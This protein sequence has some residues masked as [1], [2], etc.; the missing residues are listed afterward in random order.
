MS[1]RAITTRG[2]R[3]KRGG[4]P[5]VVVRAATGAGRRAVPVAVLVVAVASTAAVVATPATALQGSGIFASSPHWVREFP[6]TA[7]GESSPLLVDL[8]GDGTEDVVVGMHNGT[9][10]ALNGRDGATLWER[11]ALTSTSGINSSPSAADVD[12]DGRPEV[13]IG[14]GYAEPNSG[15]GALLSF[16]HDGTPRAG[17]PFVA[18]DG[19]APSRFPGIHSSPAIGDIDRDGT[20]DV[21]FGSLGIK[22]IWAVD[23]NGNVK[24]GFPYYTDD[25]NFSTAALADLDGDGITDFV[26]G[27]DQTPGDRCGTIRGMTGSG[28]QLYERWMSEIVRSSPAV[29]DVDGDGT[30]EIVVGTG[31]HWS[32]PALQTANSRARCVTGDATKLF[33]LSA[34]GSGR[35]ERIIEMEGNTSPSPALADVNGDGRTDIVAV[36]SNQHV[37]TGQGGELRVID[38]AT[39]GT[40]LRTIPGNTR[41]DII[42]GPAVADFDGDGRQD[43]A[44]TTGSGTYV[45][46]GRTGALIGQ[47][48]VGRIS[49]GATPAI[50]DLDRNGS[51]E[52]ITAGFKPGSPP[53]A[54]VQRWTTTTR[55]AVSASS[56]PTFHHDARRTGN[57]VPPPLVQQEPSLCVP[58]DKDGYWMVGGD[59]GVFPFCAAPFHGS[60]G[61]LRLAA[62]V[63]SMTPTPS[64]QGYWLVAADGGVFPFGDA[65]FFGS[66]GAIRLNAPVLT[67]IPTPTGNGY[68]LVARDG[69]VFPFGDATFLG[70]TGGIRLNQPIVG[71]KGTASGRGYWLVAADGGIFPFGDAPFHGST[72]AIRLNQPIIG[73]MTTDKDDYAL[74]ARDGGIFPFARAPFY[75]STGGIRLNQP[76]IGAEMSRSGQGY[77]LFAA[78]GG[79]FPFGDAPF[80]GSLG[81]LRLNAPVVA[82]GVPW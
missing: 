61:A 51:L 30:P 79:V 42:G 36:T 40:I 5:R 31:N 69:G 3:G 10:I 15:P 71:A 2:V 48:N 28:R 18:D 24:S 25:T 20:A 46:S 45:R 43:I 64:G 60:T 41:E 50:A 21:V 58:G 74:V 49:S 54:V 82:A 11:R 63:V 23:V 13:F 4:T 32:N 55:G 33:V 35:T 57:V 34:D 72:G 22:S 62:P 29:G 81:R 77:W 9:V 70:S 6:G 80:K 68:L 39:G 19:L 56:W 38:G 1:S 16:E 27:Q 44:V 52:M 14:S 17:F 26:Q 53:T 66:T 59:G 12:G 37:P 78:D 7:I 65:K 8:N 67:L 75:G 73:M 76:I 47:V